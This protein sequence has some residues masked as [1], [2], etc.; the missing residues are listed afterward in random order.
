MPLTAEV[1]FVHLALGV[2]EAYLLA[3]EASHDKTWLD[4]GETAG[5]TNEGAVARDGLLE[6]FPLRS[7]HPGD[8]VLSDHWSLV[9]G[10]RVGVD[11]E[12][13]DHTVYQH[14]VVADGGTLQDEAGVD[15]IAVGQRGQTVE[16]RGPH[17]VQLL[18]CEVALLHL[19]YLAD[20]HQVA[21][22]LVHRAA[23]VGHAQLIESP[24]TYDG[25][26]CQ[27]KEHQQDVA[28]LAPQRTL[29]EFNPELFHYTMLLHH[30]KGSS[31][32]FMPMNTMAPAI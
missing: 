6:G 25:G 20:R 31:I 7:G 28:Y 22:V 11:A 24:G 19:L 4:A 23:V 16:L 17:L 1:F 30:S 15:G 14:G 12:G 26:T 2:E 18:G 27:R 21:V 32:R 9:T 13:G 29:F 3:D 8:G 5:L 10:H